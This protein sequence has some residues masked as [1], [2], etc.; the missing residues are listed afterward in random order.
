MNLIFTFQ[1]KVQENLSV[2]SHLLTKCNKENV[3]SS[4]DNTEEE[5]KEKSS[6]HKTSQYKFQKFFYS[7]HIKQKKSDVRIQ[8]YID[9]EHLLTCQPG[10]GQ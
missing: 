7:Y 3:N 8:R 5:K 6:K 4:G 2:K 9:P 10:P 1:N